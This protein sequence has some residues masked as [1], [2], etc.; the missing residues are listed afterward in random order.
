MKFTFTKVG[1]SIDWNKGYLTYKKEVQMRS[2]VM[3]KI[4]DSFEFF[5]IV[6]SGLL[7]ATDGGKTGRY[8]GGFVQCATRMLFMIYNLP[9]GTINISHVELN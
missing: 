8:C 7:K 1:F 6:L 9:D 5:Q 4:K 2:A 3:A